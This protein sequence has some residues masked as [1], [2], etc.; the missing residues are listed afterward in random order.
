MD[1]QIQDT[2]EDQYTVSQAIESNVADIQNILTK[3]AAGGEFGTDAK[4]IALEMEETMRKQTHGKVNVNDI[5]SGISKF[6][7]GDMFDLTNFASTG[8]TEVIHDFSI[9]QGNLSKF[10]KGELNINPAD[11]VIGGTNLF[12]E[13]N[14]RISNMSNLMTNNTN[15]GGGGR[16]V[17][18]KVS[19]DKPL[20]M[21][22]DGEI[23]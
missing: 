9:I 18:V 10:P 22:L 3:A 20:T 2:L 13:T 19:F 23:I 8:G 11:T 21:S 16:D 5:V 17:T 1:E 7:Q 14:N 6:V 4:T 15:M 12:Q